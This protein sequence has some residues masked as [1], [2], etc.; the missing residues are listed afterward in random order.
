MTIKIESSNNLMNIQ[1]RKEFLVF[2][3][4]TFFISSI[5]SYCFLIFSSAG[6]PSKYLG[7]ILLC[8]LFV[9]FLT[10]GLKNLLT[11]LEQKQFNVD[12]K[13]FLKKFSNN[14]LWSFL[15]LFG[16]GIVFWLS[17][18]LFKFVFMIIDFDIHWFFIYLLSVGAALAYTILFFKNI[19]SLNTKQQ[20]ILLIAFAVIITSFLTLPYTWRLHDGSYSSYVDFFDEL[21]THKKNAINFIQ[22]FIRVLIL[23]AVAA[24]IVNLQKNKNS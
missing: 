4:V 11:L 2:F 8:T 14:F 1:N 22:F 6:K 10:M 23:S 21:I 15:Y 5:S 19:A 16:I 9:S 7:S 13:I 20:T 3:V 17:T 18:N 24:F 12:I